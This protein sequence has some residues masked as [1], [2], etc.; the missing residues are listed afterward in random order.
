MRFAKWKQTIEFIA[1][2][3]AWSALSWLAPEEIRAL[4][5]LQVAIVMFPASVQS[6]SGSK[7]SASSDQRGHSQPES[8]SILFLYPGRTRKLADGQLGMLAGTGGC[9]RSRGRIIGLS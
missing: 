4:E 5:E 2:N 3:A 1:R 9:C 8:S 7:K 6:L